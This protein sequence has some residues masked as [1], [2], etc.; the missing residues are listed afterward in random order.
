MALVRQSAF[1]D[2]AIAGQ[3]FKTKV[4]DSLVALQGRRNQK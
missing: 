2:D 1:R 3:E 4:N